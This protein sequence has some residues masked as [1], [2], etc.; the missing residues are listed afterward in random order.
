[1][2]IVVR[3]AKDA[4]VVPCY[5]AGSQTHMSLPMPS[6]AMQHSLE[7]ADCQFVMN[8]HSQGHSFQVGFVVPRHDVL[9][10]RGFHRKSEPTRAALFA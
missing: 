8:P 1:M 9:G 3:Q 5:V 6:L 2:E 7:N 10:G 4:H